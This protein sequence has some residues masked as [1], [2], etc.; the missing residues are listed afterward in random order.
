[1]A[2]VTDTSSRRRWLL[3]WYGLAAVL[4]V[5]T[6]FYGL[7]S[8]HIPKN[9]DE[10][11]Y[12]H[13]TRMTAAGGHWLPLLAELPEMRYTKP[14]L[15]F[16]QGIV[17]TSW[18]SNWTLWHLRWPSVIYTLL[19]AGMALLL[20]WRLS[21]QLE[22]GLLA[23]LTF[24][25]F[26][27]SYRYGRPFLTDSPSTFWLFLPCFAM[28]WRPAIIGSRLSAPLLLGLA[29]GV[30]L[31]YKSFALLLPVALCLGWWHLRQRRYVVRTFLARDAG[32]LVIV[33]VV[34]LA[35]F[36][37]WFVLD[38]DPRAIMNEFVLKENAGKFGAPGDY[39]KNL[40]WGRSSIWRLIV[41][42]PLNAGLLMFPVIALF[43]ITLKRRTELNDGETLLWM[44]VTTL[45]VV[46]VLPSQRDERYLLPAMPALAVL[47]ALNW[48]RISERAFKASLVVTGVAA[49]LLAYLSLRLE[50]T[51]AGVRLFPV[52]YWT[53]LVAALTVVVVSLL[54]P[55]LARPCVNVAILL[56][57]ASFAGFLRPF[58]G[59]PGTYS[60]DAQ[61]LV[62]GR[63]VWVPINFAAKEEGHRFL[64][65]GADVRGYPY[66]PDLTVAGL[67]ARYPLFAIRVPIHSTHIAGGRVLG[68]RLDIATRHTPGQIVDMLS[69]NVF[70]HLFVKEFL[71]ERR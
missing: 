52:A 38:P 21:G 63:T 48:Q 59:A 65:P 14:P 67:T 55:R 33:A 45:L 9:G 37:L 24:L 16:W 1:V 53:L 58:D 36:S 17:S 46:F 4:A 35:T 56:A 6:Y 41:S 71:V 49:L 54:M 20:G 30:G 57:L 7:D 19:T 43:V 62:M 23:L 61:H 60:T 3:I 69:G 68:E 2:Y 18:G 15:L 5:S 8:S 25:A 31:L 10:Y 66:E 70:E 44:W 47:C 39:L 22:T 28:L 26:F 64:L 50:Q 27:S 11:P 12:E 29:T 34:A 51:V 32:K 40:F 42:Y 13:I